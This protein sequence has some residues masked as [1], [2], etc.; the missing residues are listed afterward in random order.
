M[1]SRQLQSHN[2]QHHGTSDRLN[3]TP[4]A[5]DNFPSPGLTRKQLKQGG[6]VLHAMLALYMFWGLAIVCDEYFVPACERIC[7]GERIRQTLTCHTSAQR[8]RSA[9]SRE[10]AK[11]SF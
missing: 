7:E 9:N 4:A 1:Q 10:A 2:H 11:S 3:C 5:V 6:A 8:R